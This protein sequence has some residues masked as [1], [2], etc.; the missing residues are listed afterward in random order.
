MDSNNQP[1]PPTSERLVQFDAASR[2]I[3]ASH[4]YYEL[5]LAV[6]RAHKQN[7]EIWTNEDCKR[8]LRNDGRQTIF[9]ASYWDYASRFEAIL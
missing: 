7:P 6:H 8:V 1:R 3:E 4:T 9:V 2:R 5:Y